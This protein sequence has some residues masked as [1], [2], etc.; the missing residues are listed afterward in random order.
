MDVSTN[1]NLSDIKILTNIISRCNQRGSIWSA[2]EMSTVAKLYEKMK[3]IIE[4]SEE[5]EKE[6]HELSQNMSNSR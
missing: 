1:L 2:D 6:Q 4:Q 3:T 5:Q